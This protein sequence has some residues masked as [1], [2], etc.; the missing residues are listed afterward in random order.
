MIVGFGSVNIAYS[1]VFK[2][3]NIVTEEQSDKY[4]YPVTHWI[5][6]G[7]KGLGHYN[8]KDSQYTESFPT[9]A[10][11]QEANIEEIKNRIKD[12]GIPGLASHI[13]SKTV[14]TWE[15][16][17]YYISHHIEKPVRRNILHEFVLDEGK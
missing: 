14:W 2:S 12:F 4:E 3:M 6:M 7:L 8:L 9:K 13:A 5:M 16:G 10:E 15:D 17:T 1:A 11:K